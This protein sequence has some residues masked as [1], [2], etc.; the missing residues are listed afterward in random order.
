MTTDRPTNQQTDKASYGYASANLRNKVKR[1]NWHTGVDKKSKLQLGG[2]RLTRLRRLESL[3]DIFRVKREGHEFCRCRVAETRE[4]RRVQYSGNR[5]LRC[6]QRRNE[7][8]TPIRGSTVHEC[9]KIFASTRPTEVLQ[10]TSVWKYSL[11]HAPQ[12]FYSPRV[13]KNIR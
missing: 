11:A 12:S 8:P 5:I 10:S 4:T 9:L 1:R 13:S 7:Q 3:V 2:N 6:Y